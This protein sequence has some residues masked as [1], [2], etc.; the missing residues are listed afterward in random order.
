MRWSRVDLEQV[1]IAVTDGVAELRLGDP[2][3]DIRTMADEDRVGDLAHH[4]GL[5]WREGAEVTVG[6]GRSE[7]FAEGAY[8]EPTVVAA[9]TGVPAVAHQCG[10]GPVVTLVRL[11]SL[12][13]STEIDQ[14]DRAIAELLARRRALA[15]GLPADRSPGSTFPTRSK[16]RRSFALQRGARR[17]RVSWWPGQCSTFRVRHSP[18]TRESW[19]SAAEVTGTMGP[20]AVLFSSGTVATATRC[21]R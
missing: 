11:C 16:C 19:L 12:M 14:V 3:T 13:T 9:E 2:T 21:P 20:D 17:A 15:G 6:G 5:A 10:A 8:F 1:A 4:L 7:E 18:T